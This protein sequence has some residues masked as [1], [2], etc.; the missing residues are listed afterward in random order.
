M[1]HV[2]TIERQ[3]ASGGNE[4]G[5]KLAETLGYQLYDRNLLTKAAKALG[6][7]SMYIEGLEETHSG[8]FLFNLSTG[9][10]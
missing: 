7:P 10:F 3:Y 1:Y 2:I 6:M 4:I 8:G 5:R 9:I